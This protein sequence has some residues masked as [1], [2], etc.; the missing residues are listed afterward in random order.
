V[1]VFV[2]RIIMHTCVPVKK[3]CWFLNVFGIWYLCIHEKVNGDN[4][5]P[6]SKL[7]SRI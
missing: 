4:S 3:A 2:L 1:Y 7:L 5:S 6:Q